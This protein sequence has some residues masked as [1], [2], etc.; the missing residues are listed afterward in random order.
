[1]EQIVKIFVHQSYFIENDL[2]VDY[3]VEQEALVNVSPKDWIALIPKGWCGVDEQVAYKT[4]DSD[5]DVANL[6]IK[7]VIMEKKCFQDVVKCEKHYQLM[8]ISQNL[9]ILGRSEYF[10]FLHQSGTCNCILSS[11]QNETKDNSKQSRLS[12][13]SGRNKPLRRQSPTPHAFYKSRPQSQN[14]VVKSEKLK[15]KQ[16]STN[17][18][19]KCNASNNFLALE[20][21]YLAKIQDLTESNKVMEQRLASFEKNLV[22]TLEVI[23]KQFKLITVLSQ[24][25]QNLQKF[26]DDLVD[27]LINDDKI[28]FWAHDQEF[29]VVREYPEKNQISPLSDDC[30]LSINKSLNLSKEVYMKAIIGQQEET[31]QHLVDK[32]KDF[33][34]IFLKLNSQANEQNKSDSTSSEN[35]LGYMDSSGTT[36]Y[37]PPSYITNSLNDINSYLANTVNYNNRIEKMEINE[38]VC[39]WTNNTFSDTDSPFT[40][41]SNVMPTLSNKV[42]GKVL[43]FE[44][45][46]KKETPFTLCTQSPENCTNENEL[47]IKQ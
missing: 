46:K 35:N 13:T 14:S 36:Y 39:N 31:I 10:T 15:P 30:T 45:R 7:S 5:C 26:I 28:T 42:K 29:S 25:K 6:A 24:Q 33:F 37:S 38:N 41:E 9:E 47:N 20:S 27:G 32:I 18:C 22:H 43:T 8:Y 4:I 2:V 3:N 11:N 23:N 34:D 1:M 17:K 16:W 44:D 19:N 40:L 12:S 21:A